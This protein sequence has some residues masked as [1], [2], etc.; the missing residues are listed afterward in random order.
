[1]TIL[2]NDFLISIF[3]FVLQPSIYILQPK[4][5]HP[6]LFFFFIQQDNDEEGN[7]KIVFNS[8]ADNWNRLM[9]GLDSLDQCVPWYF[10]ACTKNLKSAVD[11]YA[12]RHEYKY[13]I[14]GPTI[15][16]YL[17]K[18]IAIKFQIP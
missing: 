15:W 9:K 13:E 17:P 12:K 6:F 18:E 2:K 8:L 4:P 11:L 5:F 1:M 10:P 7:N 16:Y 14:D 3:C